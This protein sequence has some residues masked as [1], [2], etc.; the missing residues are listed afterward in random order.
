MAR[1]FTTAVQ[2]YE[3]SSAVPVHEQD[4]TV[5]WRSLMQA[6]AL[7]A[8]LR[9]PD[10][11][12]EFVNE[13]HV[14]VL[15]DRDYIGRPAREAIPEAVSQGLIEILDRVYATGEPFVASEMPLK[16]THGTDGTL[17]DGFYTF[18]Y[19]PLRD[20]W[21]AITGIMIHADDVTEE[22]RTRRRLEQLAAE[23]TATLNQMAD[24]VIV[25]DT[26]G[27]VTFQNGAARQLLGIDAVGLPMDDCLEMIQL[28]TLD[29]SPL[30]SGEM[31]L[32]RTLGAGE[33]LL[34]VERRVRCADGME[35]IVQGSATPVIAEDGSGYGAV[36]TFRDVTEQKRLERERAQHHRELTTRV[37]QAQEDERKR[38][39]RE[40]H[41]ETVQDLTS[42]LINLDVAERHL[43]ETNGDTA[44]PLSRV[45][46]I[47]RRALDETRALA[48][49]LRPPIL[50]DVGLVAALE[51]LGEEHTQTYGMAVSVDAADEQSTVPLEPY[52]E[53]VL[54]RVA[55]EALTNACKHGHG[56]EVRI[57]LD[58]GEELA[59]LTVVD[60]GQGFDPQQAGGSDCRGGLGLDG[61]RERAALVGGNLDIASA[62][63]KGTRVTLHVPVVARSGDAP[64]Q[65]A[66]VSHPQKT[67]ADV[68]RVVL[69]D[70]HAMVR[71]GLK[72]IL[73]SHPNIRVIAEGEDGQ[74]AVTLAERL[75]PDVV[76]MDIAMPNLNGLDATRQIKRRF[77]SVK[78]LILTS[79]ENRQYVTQ[80]V[81]TGADGCLLKRSA[82]T[83]LVTALE[84][85]RDGS[86]YVSPA[87]AGTVLDDY[88][89]RIDRTG[90][91]PLTE[92]ERE[93][94][95]L[96]A[97]GH[98]NHGIARKL[99]ISIKTVETH[100]ANV[101]EKLGAVDRTDLVKY[102]IRNGMITPD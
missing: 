2:P 44:N 81:K 80:I 5:H 6:P 11:V 77:P 46:A 65:S 8:R 89:V 94:V 57:C 35:M 27:R 12:Y 79:H 72:A 32:T 82:G 78:V 1:P 96:V 95:Q 101:M 88:R 16:F 4:E 74:H 7:I 49:S 76:V 25:V 98:T 39:A 91:D 75:M 37:L 9:G 21:G 48:H 33:P 87:V 45:R 41:D 43:Q 71:E 102:A 50:D 3:E 90:E 62:P 73:E 93:V 59:T 56:R 10:H 67:A 30:P 38:I 51:A 68:L 24:G 14:Q 63:G 19:Q 83:E 22:V 58:V 42:L 13:R 15:G 18:I 100:R 36:F 47:A 54:F 61:M 20:E 52:L 23:H 28:L 64:L 55:Q 53:T 34:N 26:T 92:R 31:W 69:V 70:D 17:T 60:N 97:E 84:T 99:G 85:L 40:L 29:G 86:R 66:D